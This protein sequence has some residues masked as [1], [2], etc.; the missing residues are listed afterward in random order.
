MTTLAKPLRHIFILLLGLSLTSQAAAEKIVCVDA[1]L[2]KVAKPMGAA[3]AQ[4]MLRNAELPGNQKVPRREKIR[5]VHD[6]MVV[7]H[8][9]K[10]LPDISREDL[11]ELIVDMSKCTGHDFSMLAGLY[12]KESTYC[13]EKLNKSSRKSTASGCGQT[14]VWPIREFK[15]HLV[16]PGRTKGGDPAA[17]A[18]IMELVRRCIPNRTQDFIA[19]LSEH[20]ETVKAY[21]RNSGD[22][23]MDI[24]L[25]ALYLK[26]LYGHQGFYYNAGTKTPG[27]LSK[28]GEGGKYASL[29][30]SFAGQV[31][32]S[33][34]ICYDENEYLKEIE[35]TSCELSEDPAACS[36]TTPTFEI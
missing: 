24:F 13:L 11:S 28:Y 5:K 10:S 32:R 18:S 27:A 8:D 17:K 20:E 9:R 2:I 4:R 35:E 25:S 6:H 16:L 21:L 30:N 36:L 3:K 22:Y 1:N 19:L 31:Q 12:K 33:N 23:E 7:T 26:Y 14:T 15:N 29:V 34:L